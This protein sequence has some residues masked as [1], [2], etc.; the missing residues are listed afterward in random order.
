MYSHFRLT[1]EINCSQ[2]RSEELPLLPPTQFTNNYAVKQFY[3]HQSPP[4]ITNSKKKVNWS[5]CFYLVCKSSVDKKK[6]A[7]C[8]RHKL[9]MGFGWKLISLLLCRLSRCYLSSYLPLVGGKF[10]LPTFLSIHRKYENAIPNHRLPNLLLCEK[11]PR[12]YWHCSEVKLQPLV[13]LDCEAI[14]RDTISRSGLANL[15]S[16]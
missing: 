14:R 4:H 6:H 9:V 5:N 3:R 8:Y 16:M 12:M 2:D 13:A 11:L 10:P 15:K 1:L 7:T